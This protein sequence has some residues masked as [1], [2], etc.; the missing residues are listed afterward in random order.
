MAGH[1]RVGSGKPRV[2]RL[3]LVFVKQGAAPL[4]TNKQY[5]SAA[6]GILGVE[7][8]HAA[9]VRTLL[10]QRAVEYVKPYNI[11]VALFVEVRHMLLLLPKATWSCYLS[12]CKLCR[13]EI[14][15]KYTSKMCVEAIFMC[16]PQ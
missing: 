7:A 3:T 6:A 9:I 4:I 16:N 2:G 11:Q 1:I 8:Y 14:S 15:K 13:S 10:Y 5:L 12:T